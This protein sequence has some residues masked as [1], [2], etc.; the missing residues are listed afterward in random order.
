MNVFDHY[1][2]GITS[3][4]V[5]DYQSGTTHRMVETK[6]ATDEPLPFSW[7]QCK[8]K[9]TTVKISELQSPHDPKK[10]IKHDFN[11][12]GPGGEKKRPK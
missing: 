2:W 4:A 8:K 5:T 3:K 7:E 9:F 12:E 11:I 10:R 6:E 1:T